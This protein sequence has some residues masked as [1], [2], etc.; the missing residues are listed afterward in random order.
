MRVEDSWRVVDGENDSFD[1]SILPSVSDDDV[2][3]PLSSEQPSDG[4]P[5][6]FSSQNHSQLSQRST[7][8]I[9]DFVKHQEDEQVIL[10][11]PFRPSMTS[12]AGTPHKSLYRTPDPEFRMP[13]IDIENDRR[14]SGK[15]S[16]T[17][18][19]LIS[20]GSR[21]ASYFR[22][23]HLRQQRGAFST[24]SPVR[25][26]EKRRSGARES[27]SRTEKADLSMHFSAWVQ[28]SIHWALSVVGLAFLYAKRPLAFFL[29]IY[30]SFGAVI[31]TQN[32]VQRSIFTS[33]SPICRIPGTSFLNLPFCPT[34]PSDS[35]NTPSSPVEFEDLVTVQSKFEDVLEKSSDGVSLPFEMKRSE[36]TLRDLR[37]LLR[38]S[39]VVAKD[40]LIFEL[41]GYIDTSRQ[42]ASD[43]QRFNTHVGS[44]VDAVI[45][46]NR[47]TSRYIDSMAPVDDD[48]AGL[49]PSSALAVWTGW[50]FYPFQPTEMQ[51]SEQILREKYIEH[52]A[53]ISERIASLI[54]EAQAVLRLLTKAEDHLSLIY[55]V[56]SRSTA[57]TSSRRSETL[58]N[59]WTL[60]GANNGRLHHLSEQ[61]SLLRQ[62]DSQRTS[63][64]AQV[65][66]LVVELESIQAG[67]GDLRERV[68]APRLIQAS[69][70]PGTPLPLSIH[71]ETIDRGIERLEAARVRIRAAEDDRVRE[72]LVKSGIRGD[73]RLID[74][75]KD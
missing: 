65:S 28:N 19:A 17:A 71:I 75:Q 42:T 40:E 2:L 4:F 31:I 7:D 12:L 68:A 18:R 30:L 15:S 24:G 62:V 23:V 1:T 54:L 44:A 34:F 13:L 10:R 45:S 47:W 5:S 16:R 22:D 43:L 50:I 29:A 39:E 9:G 36:T 46:I 11:Q 32:M 72:A 56:T 33:L 48:K 66:A 74:S 6:Q 60:V 69:I 8:S 59:I 61:L 63:A 64:V 41:D 21:E 73:D 27:S 37:T 51:F 49:V 70:G 14:S 35:P 25:R 38:Q 53:L 55:D 52:T 20:S 26:K 58:W 3:L 57:A 67:L